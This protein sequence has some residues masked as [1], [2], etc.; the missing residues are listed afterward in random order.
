MKFQITKPAF[1]E[2]KYFPASLAEPI[3]I[4]LPD[5]I[6]TD[7]VSREWKPLDKK[8]QEALAKLKVKAS[9]V[10]VASDEAPAAAPA[11]PAKP[12][13]KAEQSPI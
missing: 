1:V 4:E 5:G 8:A 12:A 3:V 6:S 11:A 10:Q 7:H 13:D 2:G 9:I